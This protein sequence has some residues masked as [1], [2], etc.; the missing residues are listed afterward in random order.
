MVDRKLVKEPIFSLAVERGDE[1][2]QSAP[3]G[4]LALGG[5]PPGVE[6]RTPLA[7]KPIEYTL[8]TRD[9]ELA[10]YLITVDG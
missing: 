10:L 3:A 4:T 2:K 1:T 9:H 7:V 5:I 6:Y 8:G